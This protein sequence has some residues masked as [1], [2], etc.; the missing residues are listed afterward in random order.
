MNIRFL[1]LLKFTISF[2]IGFAIIEVLEYFFYDE[3]VDGLR[4]GKL[5]LFGLIMF[6]GFKTHIFCCV[7]P[8]MLASY[9]CRHKSC[10][11][12]YCHDEK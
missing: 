6:W 4:I 2:I 8:V 3:L 10:K 9:R 7:F 12:E 1:T 11:H 5:G